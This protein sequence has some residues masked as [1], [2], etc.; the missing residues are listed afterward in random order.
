MPGRLRAVLLVLILLLAIL[1]LG[2]AT[3]GAAEPL[4]GVQPLTRSCSVGG[5]RYVEKEHGATF[6]VAVANLKVKVVTCPK[7]R[8][9][10]G[11]VAEDILHGTKVPAR[12]GGLKVTVKEP[13]SGCT[14]DSQVSAR[15][16]QEVVTF[17]VK[18]G[19]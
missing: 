12:I 3:G 9:L 4:Q 16:G 10:A 7:A 5:L 2:A 11:T 19:A 6:S 18:G 17:T 15:S 14:P 1:A 13:C 8:S